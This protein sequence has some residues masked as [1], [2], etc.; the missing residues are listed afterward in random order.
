M[1]DRAS[2]SQSVWRVWLYFLFFVASESVDRCV[3]E[4]ELFVS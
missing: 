3:G 4:M 1:Y 2:D